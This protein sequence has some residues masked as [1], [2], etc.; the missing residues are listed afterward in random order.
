MRYLGFGQQWCNL[1]CQIL[2]T[3]SSQ[4]LL[5]GIP[6]RSISHLRGLRQGDPL[7][8]LLFILIMDV[9]NSLIQMASRNNLL[10]PMSGQQQWSRIS[11]Y[12]DNVVIFLRPNQ[13]DLCVVR[14]L[15]RCFGEVSGLKTNLIKS[16]AIPI[17]C[18]D[19][20]I[21]RTSAILSCSIG[22]LPC[23]YLGIPLSIHKPSK[24][25]LT[26]LIDKIANKLPGWKAPLLSK[27]GRLVVVK[28]VMS[29]TPIHQMLALN[30]PKWF[31]KAVHKRRRG[32]LWKGQEQA[33]GGNCLVS[34]AKVQRP[35]MFGS[36]GVHYLERMSWALCIRW[37]W[38]MKTDPSKPWFGLLVNNPKQAQAFFQ[39]AVGMLF[40]PNSGQRIGCKERVWLTL[41]QI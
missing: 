10:Q 26:P 41:L 8:P 15:L 23:S 40:L 31:F 1:I 20:D 35:Y 5:N 24:A 14:D 2:S 13:K 11:L 30:L 32:F 27:A 16:S 21:G 7:S 3:A 17:Q 28:S 37:L 12:A 34:W 6:G 29:A 18:S 4:V 36:L 25:V 38:F 22:S 19:E 9:L 39:M 33:K